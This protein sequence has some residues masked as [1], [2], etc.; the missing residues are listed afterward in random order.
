MAPSMRRQRKVASKR[1]AAADEKGQ[2]RQLAVDLIRA[3]GTSIREVS[4][5][6]GVPR[7]TV[8]KLS[9]C[10]KKN[11]SANLNKLLNP[12]SFL[13]DETKLTWKSA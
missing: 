6:S 5:K 12:V 1:E 3:G 10:I 8:Q 9:S 7:S 4:R 13:Q 11:E 2:K